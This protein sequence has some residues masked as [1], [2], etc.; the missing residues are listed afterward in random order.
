MSTPPPPEHQGPQEN[1]F[2]APEPGQ[3]PPKVPVAVA[4]P[5]GYGPGPYRPSAQVNGVAIAALVLGLLCFLP[6]VGLV[7]GVIA[8]VQIK[9]RGERG[10]AMAIGGT[11]L[12]SLGLALWLVALTTNV[13]SH[14]VQAI[15]DAARVTPVSALGVGDCFDLPPGDTIG[16]DVYDVDKTDCARPHDAEIFGVVPVDEEDFP[17]RAK[18]RDVGN[19]KCAALKPGYA[20]DPW[21]VPDDAD[22]YT[23]L[24]GRTG[25]ESGDRA[26]TCVFAHSDLGRTLTGSLRRDDTNLDDAQVA[27]LQAMS[28]IDDALYA[29]PEEYADE[30]LE[31][32]KVWA[33]EV[34][35]AIGHQAAA[36]A[37]H[38]WT[39]AAQGPVDR[40]VK[41]L[42]TARESWRKM[43]AADDEGTFYEHYDVGFEFLDGASTIGARSALGLAVTP[44]ASAAGTGDRADV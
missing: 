21:A 3:V 17:G 15:K 6:A 10:K 32:N 26:I 27:F 33:A 35:D 41:D 31:A 1:P 23:L 28:A 30:D 29:E 12:S 38:D 14:A 25:W 42:R 39:A 34:R 44:P 40:L 22:W 5:W 19:E 18:L 2:R 24:P 7:L 4:R 43:A 11:V 36:L 8:L 16:S 37:A 9:R 20:M 13:G